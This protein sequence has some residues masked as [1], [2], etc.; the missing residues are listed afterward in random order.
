MSNRFINPS[1][2]AENLPAEQ[3]LEERLKSTFG[4]VA[5]SYGFLKLETSSVEYM[6]TLASKGDVNK[7]IYTIGRA[8]GE[9]GDSEGERGLHFD[10]TVP[11]ARY[12]AQHQGKL[13]FPYRRYQIQKVWRGER[14][15]KG[16]FREF[17]QADVDVVA[18]ENL[19]LQFDAEVVVVMARIL[20]SFGIDAVTMHINNRKYLSGLLQSFGIEDATTALQLIDKLDKIGAEKVRAE[21][22]II[23]SLDDSALDLLFA[24]INERI[25]EADFEQFANNVEARNDLMKEGLEELKTLFSSLKTR[26]TIGNVSFV[27]NP[28]IA[29]GL[30]YYTGMVVETILDGFEKYGSVCSGGRYAD[31]ASRF[32]NQTLPG[33]GLSIGLTRLLSIIKEEKLIELSESTNSDVVVCLLDEAERTASLSLAETLRQHGLNVESNH[34]PSVGLG[35]QLDQAKEK[36]IKHAVI[37]EADKSYTLVNLVSGKKEKIKN[38]KKVISQLQKSINKK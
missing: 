15:Q 6:D 5:E 18:R 22:A 28:S 14:P 35:K 19:P 25:S 30:D 4:K 8:L 27:F 21:L 38:L 37:A 1:G 24:Y 23:Y 20:S 17:Y 11:F 9:E 10:L 33:V 26:A 13:Q 12:V 7:E 32:T 34:K 2:F 36:G 3:I 31:L 29:R 16:R